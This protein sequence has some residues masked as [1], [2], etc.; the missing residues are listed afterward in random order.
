MNYYNAGINTVMNQITEK[1][2]LTLTTKSSLTA[3]FVLD[4][5]TAF[6]PSS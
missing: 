4:L 5:R 2:N 1:Q 3:L 6:G